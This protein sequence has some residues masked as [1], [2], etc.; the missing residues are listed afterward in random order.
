MLGLFLSR[1]LFCLFEIGPSGF[2]ANFPKEDL[3]APELF[4]ENIVS[5]VPPLASPFQVWKE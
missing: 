3:P 1:S 4:A 5:I 2:R